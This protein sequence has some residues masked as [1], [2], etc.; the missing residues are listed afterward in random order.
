LNEKGECIVS[1]ALIRQ[2]AAYNIGS[3]PMAHLL[4]G[5]HP[6]I[7][8]EHGDLRGKRKSES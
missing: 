6:M 5:D 2:R 3:M 7:F 8:S 1:H 4:N